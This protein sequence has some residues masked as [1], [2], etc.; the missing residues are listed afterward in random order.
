MGLEAPPPMTRLRKFRPFLI[1]LAA[2]YTGW[3]T[4]VLAGGYLDTVIEHWPIALTMLFGS[5]VAGSTPMGGGTVGF[6][7]LVLLFNQDPN[8]G[9]DFSFAVQ[10]I[11][12]T[13]AGIFIVSSRVPVAWRM[14]KFAMLGS[15]VGTPAGI[16]LF[17][18]MVGG[19]AIKVLFAVVWASFG[20]LTFL[21][22]R[23][24]A[25]LQGI[26]AGYPRL[27][28]VIGLAV[29]VFGGFFVASVTGV[30][31][32]MLIY[33]ALVLIR[34]A[35]LKIA[36]PTS[37]ILMSFNSVLGIATKNLL[38]DVQAGVFENWLA[39][40]PVVALGAPLGALVVNYV[41]RVPTLLVVAT[42]CIG[43]FVWTYYVG[44]SGLGIIGLILGLAG[45]LAFQ[46]IFEGMHRIGRLLARQGR[47][48][49]WEC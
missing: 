4:L 12:M 40:A 31:I 2:F 23:G 1:W 33:C 43:Q 38:G 29:G 48:P 34:R 19:D 18:P 32:D 20:V 25:T 45:L 36:V 3:L 30:G 17:A 47:Q 8:L 44:W 14:L 7:V 21:R 46:G 42:L 5:Y 35:D 39:A 9:R 22:I 28:K 11:G 16:V 37:V 41:G 26:A 49:A 6:P 15:L 27:D 24:M 13:S 10:S